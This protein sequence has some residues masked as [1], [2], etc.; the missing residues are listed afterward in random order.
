MRAWI[1]ATSLLGAGVSRAAPPLRID[2]GYASQIVADRSYDA[3]SPNDW[4]PAVRIALGWSFALPAAGL[5]LDVA[6]LG[7]GANTAPLHEVGTMFLEIHSAEVGARYRRTFESRWISWA[8]PYG[9]LAV[10]M[11]WAQLRIAK[12]SGRNVEQWVT[13]PGAIAFLG[14]E[15][16]PPRRKEGGASW[17]KR[18]LVLDL[19]VGWS[20][21]PA[22]VFDNLRAPVDQTIADPIPE[23][24][25]SVGQVWLSGFTF[26]IGLSLK[27]GS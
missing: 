25:V 1:L 13:Q 12:S 4:L 22:F 16:G 24:P 23:A 2:L 7:G 21:K 19:S 15:V 27:L 26:R 6:Y 9:K 14:V 17:E 20:L 3:I 8:E 5:E 10:A 11:N 18:L